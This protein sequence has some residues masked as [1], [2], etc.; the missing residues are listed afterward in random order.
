M[1]ENSLPTNNLNPQLDT[2]AEVPDTTGRV[3]DISGDTISLAK[4]GESEMPVRLAT[5]AAIPDGSNPGTT[6][7]VGRTPVVDTR[8]TVPNP[9]AKTVGFGQM[10]GFGQA[11]AQQKTSL[12][13]ELSGVLP[14]SVGKTPFRPPV[15]DPSEHLLRRLRTYEGDIA[16]A[17]SHKN[18]SS[19]TIAIAENKKITGMETISNAA[20]P[21]E[22]S[23]IGRKVFMVLLS[24]ILLGGGVIG[25]Y[26]LYSISPLAPVAS[27]EVT[28]AIRT[29]L[30]PSDSRS[31][32]ALNTDSTSVILANIK[33]EIKKSQP[34][35]T[36]REIVFVPA[37]AESTRDQVGA[38]DM[39]GIM[40]ISAPDILTRSLA[41]EWML[42]VYADDEQE[43]SVF[44]VVTTN[45]FQ[46][47]F[48][49]MLQ[50]ESLMPD[51]L[52][53]YLNLDTRNISVVTATSPSATTT[54]VS[55]TTP[56]SS[57]SQTSIRGR[58]EDKIIK[59]KDVRAFRTDDGKTL[60]LYSFIDTKHLVI[61]DREATLAELLIRLEKQSFIR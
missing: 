61:T 25:A 30:I 18:I 38:K 2:P 56:T 42:G 53:A 24:I 58:F 48:A 57:A 50:W 52:R 15:D 3:F 16:E 27:N 29:S 19:S 9:A 14:S 36:I 59:N 43:K 47:A 4:E 21:T 12:Q 49:G 5:P 60:F 28:P 13:D 46:N 39:L 54:R 26:Y 7:T 31:A 32:I 17:M 35:H 1:N 10:T 23:H 33:T 11:P 45:F 8:T 51:E 20:E 55:S 34:A 37:Q 6:A 41:P 44:V 40:D 22:A